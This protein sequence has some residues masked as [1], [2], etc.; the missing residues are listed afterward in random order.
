[1]KNIQRKLVLFGLL[2]LAPKV[3]LATDACLI[4]SKQVLSD[5][6]KEVGDKVISESELASILKKV[7]VASLEEYH[8]VKKLKVFQ[9]AQSESSDEDS[10]HSN[11]S[12]LRV[13]RER[14]ALP[15]AQGSL[16]SDMLTLRVARGELTSFWKC[17]ETCEFNST[18]ISYTKIREKDEHGVAVY[19]I[20][21]SNVEK[22]TPGVEEGLVVAEF[23]VQE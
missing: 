11:M 15:S 22:E 14:T 9:S 12:S 6:V 2:L 1:M 8:E 20:N 19:T 18:N 13:A 17:K 4:R 16:Y 23:R 3:L 21:I 5:W 10:F 7:K